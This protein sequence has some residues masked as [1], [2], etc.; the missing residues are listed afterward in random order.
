MLPRSGRGARRSLRVRPRADTARP[1]ALV[2]VAVA[3]VVLTYVWGRRERLR[4][5][6]LLFIA[7]VLEVGWIAIRIHETLGPDFEW[8]DLYAGQGQELLDGSY[9][10]SEYPTGAVSQFAVEA[11]LGGSHTHVVHALLMVPF[12]LA[13]VAAIWS[14]KT[15]WSAWFAAVVA[16]WPLNARFWEFRFDLVPAALLAVGLAL[17]YR[18]G[19]CRR[20]RLWRRRRGEVEPCGRAAC[21]HRVPARVAPPAGRCTPGA[22]LHRGR[23]TGLPSLPCLGPVR[24][25]GRVFAAGW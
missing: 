20:A 4:L 14:L 15:R 2:E 10:R 7:L 3:A 11:L 5:E 21:A 13:T 8:R 6:P 22:R 23:R 17:S 18:C 24:G 9:P 1:W 25:A 19:G 12:Q 16:F